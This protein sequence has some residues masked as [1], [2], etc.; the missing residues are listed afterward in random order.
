M[1]PEVEQAIATLQR[2]EPGAA[3]KA[4]ALLQDTVFSFSMK[5]C[6]HR[7]DAEDT[8]QETLLQAVRKLSSFTNPKALAVWLYKVAKSRCLM[9]RRKSKFAPKEHLSIEVLMPDRK[10]LERLAAQQA[11]PERSAMGRQSAE[12]LQQAVLK[13]PPEYRLAL[14]LHDME[15]LSAEEI[16]KVLRI[17]EGNVRVRL[18][19][20]RVFVRNEL[21][22]RASRRD[23][24]RAGQPRRPLRC[25]KLFAELSGYLD[26]ELDDSLCDE[27][28]EHLEGCA[29]CQVFLA[30]LE[31]TVKQCRRHQTAKLDR[32]RAAAIR[33]ELMAQY[34]QALAAARSAAKPA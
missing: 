13:L 7:E 10:E 19:R 22:G 31:R 12:R 29:P 24:Q 15:E 23:A 34:Q 4:L 9:S 20:A 32:E 18:H 8:M 27:I 17:S 28:E 3:E 11:T 2:G 30:S 16:A 1:R 14:V 33:N 26:E 5:V 6:G 25:K 21:A